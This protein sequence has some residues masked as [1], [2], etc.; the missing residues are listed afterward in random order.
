VSDKPTE[1]VIRRQWDKDGV[2]LRGR[3][4]HGEVP[5]IARTPRGDPYLCLPCCRV[6][7]GVYPERLEEGQR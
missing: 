6:L 3:C 4:P 7:Q 1:D 2:T 5:M